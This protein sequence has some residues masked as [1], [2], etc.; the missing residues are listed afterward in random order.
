MVCD[1]QRR[2]TLAGLLRVLVDGPD[3]PRDD[4]EEA[5]R[6]YAYANARGMWG[7]GEYANP[8]VAAGPASPD[9]DVKDPD[10]VWHGS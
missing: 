6:R 10:G 5:K 9:R 3:D 1:N 2:E 8:P 7:E 4:N